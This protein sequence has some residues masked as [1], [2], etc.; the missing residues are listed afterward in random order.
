MDGSQ[1]IIDNLKLKRD[2]EDENLL[3]AAELLAETEVQLNARWGE[4][5]MMP[6]ADRLLA[7]LARHKAGSSTRFAYSCACLIIEYPVHNGCGKTRA[8]CCCRA[9][10]SREMLRMSRGGVQLRGERTTSSIMH[11]VRYD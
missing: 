1:I 7:H 8:L 2:A 10:V 6:G 9:S 5:Q 3:T 11:R 4:V